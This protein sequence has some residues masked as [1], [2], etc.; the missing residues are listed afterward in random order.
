MNQKFIEVFLDNLQSELSRL[1]G[2]IYWISPITSYGLFI[3]YDM[4]SRGS[5]KLPDETWHLNI[6][7]GIL[8]IKFRRGNKHKCYGEEIPIMLSN[9]DDFSIEKLVG[10][11][12]NQH[13]KN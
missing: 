7:D 11:I 8:W 12:Q 9:P 6:I 10:I 13:N 3:G 2:D 1:L 4:D 5:N